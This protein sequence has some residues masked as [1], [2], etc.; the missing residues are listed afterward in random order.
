MADKEV[1]IQRL[2]IFSCRKNPN[3]IDRKEFITSRELEDINKELRD[4]FRENILGKENIRGVWNSDLGHKNAR[5][6]DFLDESAL[7]I[8]GELLSSEENFEVKSTELASRYVK[9]K[10][11][12]NAVIFIFTIQIPPNT[13]VVIYSSGYLGGVLSFSDK[14]Q[15]IE[16]IKNVFSRGLLKGLLYPFEAGG[17]LHYDK[18]KVYQKSG[19]YAIYWWRAFGLKEEPSN[20]EALAIV[21]IRYEREQGEKMQFTEENVKNIIKKNKR[22]ANSGI[23]LEIDGIKIHAKLND[24]YKNIIP[25]TKDDEKMIM[26]KGKDISVKVSE[27]GFV[28][29]QYG[30]G[31]T[32]YDE[33]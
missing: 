27:Y 24:L 12:Q 20:E 31:Y 3:F 9:T 15:L 25:V 16:Q 7:A 29:F 5:V 4:I 22:I 8:F 21:L 32:E 10:K 11:S 18:A 19:P 30:E 23:I 33:I 6:H 1:E 2:A 28:K 26:V 17:E 13:Y 14:E